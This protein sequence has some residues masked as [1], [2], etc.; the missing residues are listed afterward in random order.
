M[1]FQMLSG[2]RRRLVEK[3]AMLEHGTA[4]YSQLWN[5][6]R[7]QA[8]K[9]QPL[10]KLEGFVVPLKQRSINNIKSRSS[11]RREIEIYRVRYSGREVRALSVLYGRKEALVFCEVSSFGEQRIH[12]LQ[13]HHFFQSINGSKKC[14]ECADLDCFENSLRVCIP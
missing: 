9:Q 1:Q 6:M 13:C 7:N 8:E 10:E 5:Q 12:W 11:W 2:G 4:L 3:A 14:S